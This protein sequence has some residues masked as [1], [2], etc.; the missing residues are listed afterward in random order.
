MENDPAEAWSAHDERI[1]PV[2]RGGRVFVVIEEDAVVA[3][4]AEHA[5][6]ALDEAEVAV[7]QAEIEGVIARVAVQEGRQSAVALDTDDIVAPLPVYVD[8]GN[9]GQASREA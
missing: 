9:A 2:G 6:L 3:G 7:G 8:G 4:V 5:G 1:D